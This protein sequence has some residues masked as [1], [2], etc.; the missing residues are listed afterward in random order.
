MDPSEIA[1]L[2][3]VF[4]VLILVFVGAYF[5]LS[6]TRTKTST[7]MTAQQIADEQALSAAIAAKKAKA[8]ADAQA[9]A[10]AA[11]V[12]DAERAKMIADVQAKADAYAAAVEAAKPV[13]YITN[14]ATIKI[15][16][17]ADGSYSV[18][19]GSNGK[20]NN[21]DVPPVGKSV[22]YS[23]VM[24]YTQVTTTTSSKTITGGIHFEAITTQGITGGEIDVTTIAYDVPVPVYNN[25]TI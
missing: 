11:G 12:S 7:Q 19:I 20:K 22:T 1:L 9:A 25:L 23:P 8:V 14:N 16:A 2:V 18:S 3:G 13:T 21:L 6:T 15:L 24:G 5:A 10:T 17:N 4:V